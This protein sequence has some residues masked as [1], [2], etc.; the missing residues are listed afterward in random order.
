MKSRWAVLRARR[1]CKGC[2]AKEHEENISSGKLS[3]KAPDFLKMLKSFKINYAPNVYSLGV[4]NFDANVS[5]GKEGYEAKAIVAAIGQNQFR[6]NLTYASDKNI[7][8]ISG[9]LNINQ[10]ELD[11]ILREQLSIDE[12]RE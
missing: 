7:K 10:L 12:E 4:F 6:G 8:K 3:V 11:R 1:D 5:S 2:T 9:N